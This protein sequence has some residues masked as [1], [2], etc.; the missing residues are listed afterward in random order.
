MD[1]TKFFQALDTLLDIRSCDRIDSALNGVQVSGNE[2]R[3]IN[4]VIT[5]VDASLEMIQRAIERQ[6]DCLLVHH[7]IL[8]GHEGH[9][10][11]IVGH[12]RARIKALLTS[13]CALYAAHLPLDIHPTLGNNIAIAERLQLRDIKPFGDYRGTAIGYSGVLAT[14]QSLEQIQQTLLVPESAQPLATLPFGPERCQRV[15]V[16]SGGGHF[17]LAEAIDTA[18][19][20]LITGDI[21]YSSYYEAQES[22][23]SI[24]CAGHYNTEIHGVRRVAEHLSKEFTVTAEFID[25][26]TGL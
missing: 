12:R 3:E 8:W 14:P 23:I 7:G 9:G 19:D 21:R 20:L 26:P 11:G 22:G 16:V 6:A 25:L 10:G 4:T 5:A 24:L 13:G 15:G 2:Q 17:S 1:S 18:A